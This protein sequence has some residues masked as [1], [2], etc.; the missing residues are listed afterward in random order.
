MNVWT[1]F[2]EVTHCGEIDE[3]FPTI[4]VEDI[5]DTTGLIQ[6]LPSDDSFAIGSTAVSSLHLDLKLKP[7]MF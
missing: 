2:Q 7:M 5:F 6:M 4:S 1:K 3:L